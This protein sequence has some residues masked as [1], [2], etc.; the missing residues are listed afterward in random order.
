MLKN[1]NL[2]MLINKNTFNH[3]IFS[4]SLLQKMSKHHIPSIFIQKFM[5]SMFKMEK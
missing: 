5:E 4:S 3:L 1:R 2:K